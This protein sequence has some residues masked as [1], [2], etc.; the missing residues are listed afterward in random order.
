MLIFPFKDEHTKVLRHA[1]PKSDNIYL[2]RWEEKQTE[3]GLDI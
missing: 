2:L 1:K 3:K